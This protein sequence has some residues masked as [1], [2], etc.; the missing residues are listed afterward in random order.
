MAVWVKSSARNELAILQHIDDSGAGFELGFDETHV[1]PDLKR[2][3]H[4][5]FSLVHQRPD[6]SIRIQTKERFAQGGWLYVAAVYDGSGKAS[7]MKL[8]VDG[9]P[10][11]FDV[12]RDNLSGPPPHA[13]SLQIGAK[14]FANPYKGQ[15]DD[16]RVY[17]R[18][19]TTE[20][21]EQLAIV[22]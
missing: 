16:L 11:D 2:G 9:I 1:I 20:E 5:Q 7:G 6:D 22:E 4:V 19:L 17:D 12:I 18:P 10:S 14:K 21:I 3:S 8:Y 15:L 13:G